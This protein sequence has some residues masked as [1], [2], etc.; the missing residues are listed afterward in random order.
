[1]ASDAP[2]SC[3]YRI[4]L[5][6]DGSDF[7]G[8]QRQE[9][10]NAQPLRTVQGVVE[11]ALVRLLGQPIDLV[12]ASRTD[13]GVHALGQTAHFDAA[14]PIPPDRLLKA[15]RHRLPTDIDVRDLAVVGDDFHAIRNVTSKQYRYRI[16]NHHDR[17]IFA[18][19]TVMHYWETL[20]VSVM[21][22]AC[23]HFVGR[24][25][26][27]GFAAAGHG[28]QSTVRNVFDC[29]VESH[30]PQV[31][32]VV[33]GDGF[34]WNQ[35]RIMVGTL[36]DIGRGRYDASRIDQV[37]EAGDRTLAGPTVI[38]D[39]LCLEWIR[40]AGDDASNGGG[41]ESDGIGDNNDGHDDVES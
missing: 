6:Y 11:S 22:D 40:Y 7:H 3:R 1:M 27:A 35:I 29:H 16:H 9:P 21:A 28:R 14:T 36:I 10:P 5:A 38:P 32:I 26:F 12:G 2:T 4:K 20:D 23:S 17:P 41:G 8:W 18:R 25:D 30:D 34:L 24:H 19:K 31:H 15:I 39:G 37:L 13:A 33:A